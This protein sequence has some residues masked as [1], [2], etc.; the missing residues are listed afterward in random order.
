MISQRLR[1][2]GE[3][4]EAIDGL[5]PKLQ[6]AFK[7]YANIDIQDENGEL[8]STYDILSDL[9]KVYPSL[10]SK[11]RQYLGELAAG[12][13]QVKVLNSIVSN[14]Q[15]VEQAVGTATN[16]VG[17]AAQENA[18]FMDS[19]Q[20]RLNELQSKFQ[21][22]SANIIDS[23]VV[24]FFIDLGIGVLDLI[25][26]L[27]GLQTI[28]LVVSGILAVKYGAD[29]AKGVIGFFQDINKSVVALIDNFKA[30]KAEGMSFFDSLAT[31]AGTT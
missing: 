31:A 4:G 14:W 20:G 6:E 11:Q 7:D 28:L 30:G 13:R 3:D 23:G 24:K 21:E 22:F 2:I 15:D 12:N 26:T 27:G 18:A 17:S 25:D 29:A 10:T 5:A 16:S 19:I 1:G 8:R 9:A